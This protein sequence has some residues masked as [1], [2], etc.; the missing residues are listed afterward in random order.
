MLGLGVGF[1]GIRFI[2][3]LLANGR[4]QFTLRAA[5]NWPVLGFTFALAVVAGMLFGLAPAIQA[6]KV[7]FTPALKENRLQG[8]AGHGHRFRPRLGHTLIVLQIAVSLLLVIGAGLFVRT[9]A[10]LH[11]IDV[12]FNRENLSA[13]HAS[14]AARAVIATPRSPASTPGLLDRF[15]ADSRRAR[16]QR[17]QFPAGGALRQ[18]CRRHRSRPHAAAGRFRTDIADMST[19]LFSKPCR[20][21][22]CWAAT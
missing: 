20:F 3:W 12:G 14:T 21:P 7:D 13:G 4:D 9:L 11:A 16:R 6:T 10:N 1:A 18:R 22:C 17:L 15:R 2:T 19:R 8:S 5:L